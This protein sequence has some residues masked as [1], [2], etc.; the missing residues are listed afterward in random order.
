MEQEP[1]CIGTLQKKRRRLSGYV[2]R[3]FQLERDGRLVQID[4]KKK[5]VVAY[6]RP[7]EA[8]LS[9]DDTSRSIELSM[10]TGTICLRARSEEDYDMWSKHFNNVL[11]LR[12][13]EKVNMASDLEDERCS[14]EDLSEK[15]E[16]EEEEEE[17]LKM[18]KPGSPTRNRDAQR[19]GFDLRK[20]VEDTAMYAAKQGDLSN[21]P[22]EPLM[23][24]KSLEQHL[25]VA[26]TSAPTRTIITA[27]SK[28]CNYLCA[29][30]SDAVAAIRQDN[31]DLILDKTSREALYSCLGKVSGGRYVIGAQQQI[32]KIIGD[33]I[34]CNIIHLKEYKNKKEENT[35]DASSSSGLIYLIS[36]CEDKSISTLLEH[37]ETRHNGRVL[38]LFSETASLDTM[39]RLSTCRNLRKSLCREP[40][41]LSGNF[42]CRASPRSISL[43]A[44]NFVNCLYAP[45]DQRHESAS[46]RLVD[47]CVSVCTALGEFPYVRFIS[48]SP[49]STKFAFNLEK[50]LKSYIGSHPTFQFKSNRASVRFIT[51]CFL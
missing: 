40:V 22:A 11:Q 46:N 15:E 45:G 34:K 30:I 38:I 25:W 42:S 1:L 16:E 50:S 8:L 41:I 43:L 9:C 24:R 51:L 12:S 29:A 33:K 2:D 49:V 47:R 23:K 36:P 26:T 18:N 48:S 19:S 21:S 14:H 3:R 35:D 28:L 7:N 5:K 44:S 32:R 17:E 27:R 39:K 31:I 10:R 37:F 4:E 6:V 13:D 20:E